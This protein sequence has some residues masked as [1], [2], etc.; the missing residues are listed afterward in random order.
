MRTEVLGKGGAICK[1]LATGTTFIGSVSR[2]CSH[3]SGDRTALREPAITHWTFERLFSAVSAK[4]SSEVSGLSEGLLTNGTLVR[5]LT[6]VGAEVCLQSRLPGI[7]LATYVTIVGP[8]KRLI[9]LLQRVISTPR[10]SWDVYST[11]RIIRRII[12]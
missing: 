4:V 3:V 9:P 2:V 7:S 5:L 8:W 10:E 6:G 12:S 11:S 1:S